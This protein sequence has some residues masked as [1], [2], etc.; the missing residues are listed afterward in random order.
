MP[1]ITLVNDSP[2]KAFLLIYNNN[3]RIA[4]TDMVAPSTSA[5]AKFMITNINSAG[6]YVRIEV[7]KR[8]DSGSDKKIYENH[9][10]LYPRVKYTYTVDKDYNV[11][12]IRHY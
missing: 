12:V 3:T 7:V 5:Q 1:Q 9:L 4:G 8:A 11:I 6:E 10:T 2:S